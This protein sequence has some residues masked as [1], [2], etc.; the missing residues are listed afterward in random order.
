M[1]NPTL[2]EQRQRLHQA[3]A[4]VFDPLE[5]NV[6]LYHRDDVIPPAVTILNPR[7]VFPQNSA[8]GMVEW[9]V[10]IYEVRKASS[11]VAKDF[12]EILGTTLLALAKGLGMGFVLNRVENAILNDIGYPLPGYVIV[13]TC[14]LANC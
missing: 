2:P 13:S 4:G 10:R 1:T 3:L 9:S 5:I 14:P 12:D 8:V 11:G 6:L 7:I